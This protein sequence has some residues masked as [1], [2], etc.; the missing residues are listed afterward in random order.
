MRVN[1]ITEVLVRALVVA[2]VTFVVA[3]EVNLNSEG[4][5]STDRKTFQVSGT[6]EVELETFD[7]AIEIHSW[8][9]SEVEVEVEK[10]A[11]DQGLVD[12]MQVS[13]VQDGNRIVVR[14]TGPTRRDFGGVQVGFQFG[15][16][17][18]L[19]VALPRSANV[20]ATSRDGS[21]AVE[22]VAGT[23][24]LK[25][26]D[27]S[28]RGSRLTGQV[29]ARSG[30]GSIR[31]DRIDGKL[32]VETDDGSVTIE[33]RATAVRARTGDGSVRLR[34][35]PESSMSEDWDIQTGDGSVTLTLPAGFNA[36]LDAETRDGAVRGNHPGITSETRTGEDREERQRKLKATIGTGGRT[37]RV[38]TGDGT[39]RI[40][41]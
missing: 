11:M 20:T 24:S 3:C 29:T 40:E 6:A 8:D 23:I 22:D 5:V 1:R 26:D 19:R 10:R 25:T 27:G 21:V 14:V 35:E 4:V 41:S 18:R 30:D 28:V 9:R 15:P 17:A 32:D 36:E 2:S 13:A 12:Q 38:R 34:L 31:L 39:I 33:A 7:G 37:L 16:S